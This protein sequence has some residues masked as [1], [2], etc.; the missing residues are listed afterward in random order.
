MLSILEYTARGV[1][2]YPIHSL[3]YLD[4][5]HLTFTV[6]DVL[7][8]GTVDTVNQ[9]VTLALA[10][11]AGTTVRIIRT[12]PRDQDD[13]LTQF[14]DLATG[15]AGLT[16]D[17]LDQDYR[18]NLYIL[19][20]ARDLVEGLDPSS[21][22]RIGADGNWDALALRITNLAAGSDPLD[23]ITKAQ[24]DGI[25]AATTPLPTVSGADDDDGLFVAAGVWAKRTPAQVRTHLGLGTAAT[26]TLG[27][28]ANNVAQY[29][30]SAQYRTADGQNIDLANH[31]LVNLRAKTTVVRLFRGLTPA[32]GPGLDPAVNT[33]SH[34]AGSRLI[35]TGGGVTTTELDNGGSD[36][37]LGLSV[38]T[39]TAGT[40]LLRW[41]FLVER[42][43]TGTRFGLRLTNDDNT[44]AQTVYYDMSN[45]FIPTTQTTSNVY[46]GIYTDVIL[47]PLAVTSALVFRRTLLG[48]AANSDIQGTIY[49]HKISNSVAS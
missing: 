41:H 20:E 34:N 7:V 8:A 10:P 16:G 27:V 39:L 3:P 31:S 44:S 29:D 21:G 45:V 37:A 42:G 9:L 14:L 33:W 17:L 2:P 38:S 35:I 13:R 26:L 49:Y 32:T 43:G 6:N 1:G 46:W 18:Q 19:G 5:A 25:D 28:G 22:M 30:G 4:P 23:L 36:V 24:L 48:G 11:A 40:W 47:L 15:A 12:T